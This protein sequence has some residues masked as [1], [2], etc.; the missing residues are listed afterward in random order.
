LIAAEADPGQGLSDVCLARVRDPKEVAVLMP[1][2]EKTG[3]TT[4]EACKRLGL[5][6]DIVRH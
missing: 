4:A 2:K 5:N 6:E 1:P 3:L